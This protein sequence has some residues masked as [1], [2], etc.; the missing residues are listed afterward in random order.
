M[1]AAN[2]IEIRLVSAFAAVCVAVVIFVLLT[3][4]P[5]GDC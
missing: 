4:F 1:N 5:D 2:A 3:V